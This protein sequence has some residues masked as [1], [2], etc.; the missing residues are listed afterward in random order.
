VHREGSAQPRW[1]TALPCVPPLVRPQT[2]GRIPGNVVLKLKTA[3]HAVFRR[4]GNDLHM[5]MKISLRAALL[6]FERTI[7]HLDGRDV[8]IRN[9]AI[10]THGQVLTIKG[11][12]MPIHGVPSEFGVLRVTLAVEMPRELSPAE[13][14]FVES[15]FEPQESQGPG[16]IPVHT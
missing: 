10:S 2:P 3:R 15:H 5:I 14:A 7:R 12:G 6:G 4:D 11:E 13:R 16:E 1:L 9:D 8:V